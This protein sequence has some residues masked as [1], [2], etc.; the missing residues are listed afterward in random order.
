MQDELNEKVVVL[1]INLGKKGLKLTADF[2]KKA[3]QL[4][5]RKQK[6]IKTKVK[7]SVQEQKESGKQSMK[8][9]MKKN[10]QLTNIEVTDSNIK[11]FEKIARKYNIDFALKR[12]KAAENPRYLVFFKTRDVDVMT[13]A[14]KEYSKKAEVLKDKPSVRQ[15]LFLYQQKIRRQQREKVKQRTRQRG[16]ER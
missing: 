10:T 5:L 7:S 6:E 2:L 13:A 4:Y 16:Q 15:K 14:F 3:M 9:M 12:D 8:S 11:S 1:T